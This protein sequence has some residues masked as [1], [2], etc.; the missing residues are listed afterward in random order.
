M[1][2][3][4]QSATRPLHP[5]T[6]SQ[7]ERKRAAR[8]LASE[9]K[10]R[11]QRL[12]DRLVEKPTKVCELSNPHSISR[13][14]NDINYDH[15]WHVL[16]IWLDVAASGERPGE[17]LLMALADLDAMV[18]M[19][20]DRVLAAGEEIDPMEVIRR[21]AEAGAADDV[22]TVEA[23]SDGEISPPDVPDLKRVTRRDLAATRMKLRA[24]D[25]IEAADR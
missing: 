11:C 9:L 25:L 7:R 18:A 21:E 8:K 23:L 5:G 1:A 6:A 19:I 3:E 15:H 10:E 24:L 14:K 20:F 16:S 17:N 13:G 22:A 12:T 4:K 2:T